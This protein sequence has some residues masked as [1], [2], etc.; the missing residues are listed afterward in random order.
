M[1]AYIV[2]GTKASRTISEEARSQVKAEWIAA[3][4]RAEGYVV[5]ITKKE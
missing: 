1:T 2:T 5:T 4:Y 3:M